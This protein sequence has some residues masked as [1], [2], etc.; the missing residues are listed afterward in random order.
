V[1]MRLATIEG[2]YV[3]D[4]DDIRK[5]FD[6][7]VLNDE[8]GIIIVTES[9]FDKMKD[10]VLEVKKSNSK[11]LIVTVP[12]RT[13]LKDKDFIMRYIKESVGIKI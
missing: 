4:L 6:D 7:A 5:A 10:R 3:K 11:K 9:I 2:I 13:G 8:I 1:G 12:D